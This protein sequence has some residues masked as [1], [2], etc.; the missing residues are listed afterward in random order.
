[1][2]EHETVLVLGAGASM[3][4]GYPSGKKLRELLVY[5]PSFK[6]ALIR[7][8]ITQQDVEAFCQIF[9]RSGLTSIDA[10]LSRMGTTVLPG[11]KS[12]EEIGK[13]GISLALRKGKTLDSL[14]HNPFASIEASL[15]RTDHWYEYLWN[16]LIQ[17]VTATNIDRFAWNRL[18]IVTFNYDLSLEHYLFQAMRNAYG[19][20]EDRVTELLKCIKFIHVYGKLSGEPYSDNFDYNF[21][22]ARDSRLLQDDLKLI[23]VIDERRTDKSQ[24]FIDA[25]KALETAEKIC[26]LGFGF[27][28]TNVERLQLPELLLGRARVH[29]LTDRLAR[30]WPTI[31]ATTLGFEEAER[32]VLIST[33][34]DPIENSDSAKV[35][36]SATLHIRRAFGIEGN[37]RSELLLRRTQILN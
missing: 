17:G 22:I 28:P 36:S 15:E 7:E 34:V 23:D 19:I 21:D 5:P 33:L 18:T 32:D 8:W 35:Y 13:I 2:I 27:D 10:F 1:M 30:R 26:F 31:A 16:R 3:P 20:P 11:G 25:I 9:L 12:I 4:Y 6:P 29:D 37:C 24:G 14:F